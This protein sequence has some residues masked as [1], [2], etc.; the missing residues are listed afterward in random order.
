MLRYLKSVGIKY[1]P[2]KENLGVARENFDVISVSCH[3]KKYLAS[4]FFCRPQSGGHLTI[5]LY[6]HP[7]KKSNKC[8]D[9]NTAEKT[10]HF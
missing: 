1:F 5:P 3:L 7:A 10:T 8:P 4:F 2:S 6:H 9:K